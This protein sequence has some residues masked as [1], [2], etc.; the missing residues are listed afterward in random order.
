MKIKDWKNLFHAIENA[1]SIV[2]QAFQIKNGIMIYVNVSVKSIARAK[3][4]IAGILAHVLM[5]IGSNL[6]DIVD[7][8]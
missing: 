4:I 6:K 8:H 1:D 2:Q 5:K 7:V 3:N